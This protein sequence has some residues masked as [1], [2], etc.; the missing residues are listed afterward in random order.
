[1]SNNIQILVVDDNHINRQYFSMALKKSGYNVVL[2]ADGFEAIATAKKIDFHLILMDIRMPEMD[3]YTAAIQIRS[4]PKYKNIPILATSAESYNPA[5]NKVFDDFLLKPVSPKQLEE[6]I[7]K[8]CYFTSKNTTKMCD[9]HQALKYAYDDNNIMIKLRRMFA[10]ELPVQIKLLQLNMKHN[11]HTNCL[12]I[13]HK[14]RGSCQTCGA[15]ELD[16][17]L[18]SLVQA[19][20]TNDCEL[21]IN[22]LSE[23][24]LAVENFQAYLQ[25]L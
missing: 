19:I 11:K 4:I 2:A 8:H 17:Q 14:L 23:V 25:Q 13:I 7:K 18:N 12:N 22:M 3:G 15:Q 10:Q 24:N 1:M 9:E 20:K 16:S 5:Y 21:D 6:S